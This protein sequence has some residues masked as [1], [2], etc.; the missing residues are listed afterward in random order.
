M[1]PPQRGSHLVQTG[2]AHKMDKTPLSLPDSPLSGDQE[3]H[4]AIWIGVV[5]TG[6]PTTASNGLPPILRKMKQ[7]Q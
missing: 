7:Q 2:L 3:Q 6:V 4:S 5:G 1:S